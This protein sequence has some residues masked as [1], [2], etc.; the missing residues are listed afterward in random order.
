MRTKRRRVEQLLAEGVQDSAVEAPRVADGPRRDRINILQAAGHTSHETAAAEMRLQHTG[1]KP[2]L[3]TSAAGGAELRDL[4][5]AMVAESPR[6]DRIDIQQAAGDPGPAARVARTRLEHTGTE[7]G[8]PT[9]TQR[10]ANDMPVS[11]GRP[12]GDPPAKPK[13]RQ[14]KKPTVHTTTK[15]SGNYRAMRKGLGAK[16]LAH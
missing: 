16:L 3:S 1:T 11:G 10:G 13:F 4:A 12:Q 14:K 2:G 9:T 8:L 15:N 5:E 7:A 6:Q